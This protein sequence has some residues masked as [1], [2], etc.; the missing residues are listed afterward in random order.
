MLPRVTTLGRSTLYS[1][2]PTGATPQKMCIIVSVAPTGAY[3]PKGNLPLAVANG[4]SSVIPLG[5]N[6]LSLRDKICRSSGTHSLLPQ[7][8]FRFAEQKQE[9]REIQTSSIPRRPDGAWAARN[10]KD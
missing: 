7:F 1:K 10:I 6:P 9:K 3:D 4:N 2:A 5:L 8:D